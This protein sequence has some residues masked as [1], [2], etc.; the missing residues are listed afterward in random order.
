MLSEIEQKPQKYWNGHESSDFLKIGPIKKGASHLDY[1][2]YFTAHSMLLLY[3]TGNNK[4]KLCVWP[5][6]NLAY[7]T[8][9]NEYETYRQKNKSSKKLT[10]EKCSFS[11]YGDKLAALNSDGTLFMFNF[12][13][14]P[15]SVDPFFKKVKKT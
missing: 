9:G 13:M 10:I 2:T 3:V 6:K 12:N 8:V 14:C 1:S 15:T 4:G 11:S 5:F 7:S